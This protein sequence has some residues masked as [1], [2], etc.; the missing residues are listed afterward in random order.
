MLQEANMAMGDITRTVIRGT[1]VDFSF[2]YFVTRVGY[3]TKKPYPLPRI[4][5][6]VWPFDKYLWLCLV[7]TLPI[8]TLT[9]LIWAKLQPRSENVGS[10]DLVTHV[11]MIFLYQ[12][13]QIMRSEFHKDM[14]YD[15]FQIC[16]IGHLFGTQK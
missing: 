10:Q 15:S 12:S 13:K 6:I 14:K 3:F 8:F 2:P 4:E 1:A 11:M 7:V 9:Y 5:S 16:P